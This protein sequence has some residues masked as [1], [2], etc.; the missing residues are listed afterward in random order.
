MNIIGIIGAVIFLLG[1]SMQTPSGSPIEWLPYAVT[2][3]GLGM[4][5]AWHFSEVVSR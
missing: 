4:I 2:L 5:V 3:I 1:A